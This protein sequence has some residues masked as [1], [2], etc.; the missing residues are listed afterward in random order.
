[1]LWGGLWVVGGEE[2]RQG[3]G[4][5]RRWTKQD[6][7]GSK[8]PTSHHHTPPPPPIHLHRLRWGSLSVAKAIQ[9][10]LSP[11]CCAAS[12]NWPHTWHT[13]APHSPPSRLPNFLR[14]Q[15]GCFPPRRSLSGPHN[16]PQRWGGDK[17]LVQLGTWGARAR[18]PRAFRNTCAVW[19]GVVCALVISQDAGE[20]RVAVRGDDEALRLA[21][22]LAGT[23]HRQRT[24]KYGKDSGVAVLSCASLSANAGVR[25]LCVCVRCCTLPNNLGRIECLRRRNARKEVARF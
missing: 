21:E 23:P 13:G 14:P 9:T 12:S 8:P 22:D 3:F 5:E 1:L 7:Y 17:P 18:D 25:A 4:S 2:E 15:D 16:G 10:T 6:L 24:K 19:C 20:L 11:T